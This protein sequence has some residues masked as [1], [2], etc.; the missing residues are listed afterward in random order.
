MP[1]SS[2]KEDYGS[3]SKQPARDDNEYVRL[4]I[5]TETRAAETSS[6]EHEMKGRTQSFIWWC[7]ALLLCIVLTIV[8]LIFLKWG[9][10][11]LFEKVLSFLSTPFYCSL[12]L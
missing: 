4:V 3:N 12:Y 6:S 1:D 2:V 7:K 5:H 11:F 9:V 8:L 10:P